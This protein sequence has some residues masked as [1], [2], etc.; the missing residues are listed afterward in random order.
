MVHE[1]NVPHRR[2]PGW[3]PGGVLGVGAGLLLGAIW[4]YGAWDVALAVTFVFVGLVAAVAGA[5]E[6]RRFALGLLGAAVVA[7]GLLV[8]LR[9]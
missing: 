7:G 9:S 1:L 2:R 3:V 6:W 4:R 5:P 8:L